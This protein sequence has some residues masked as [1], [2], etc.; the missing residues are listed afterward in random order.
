[1]SLD[2][3]IARNTIVQIVGRLIS[4]GAGLVVLAIMTRSLRTE[5]FGK[6]ATVIGFLQFIATVIDFGL[7]LTANRMLGA[8]S[9]K[10]E[11]AR[12]VGNIMAVRVITAIACLGIAPVIAFAGLPYPRD[13]NVGIAVV[14]FSFFAIALSQTL[15]P[16]FQ[17]YLAMHKAMIADLAGRV[18][19]I[20]GI[21]IAAAVNA[22]LFTFMVMI[23]AGSVT[24]FLVSNSLVRR[25]VPYHLAYDK[26]VWHEIFKTTWPIGLSI[27]FNLIYLRTDTLILSLYKS[28]DLSEVGFYSAAYR[29]LDILTGIATAFMGIMLPQLTAA[30]TTSNKELFGQLFQ[31][32]FNAFMMLAL[33]TAAVGLF[34]GKPL[35]AFIAGSEYARSGTI[36]SILI[37]AMSAVY[38]ST[39]YGH[40]IVVF[41]L[42]RRMIKGYAAA[43]VLGLSAYLITIPRY[44]V[45]GAAASTVGTEI[46][47]LIVTAYMASRY[48]H[49]T[50][51][52]RFTRRAILAALSMCLAFVTLH[53][54]P[55]V[56]PLL[57][58]SV[59]YGAGLIATKAIS[60]KFLMDLVR[61]HSKAPL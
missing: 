16:V 4:T 18:V 7:T 1:M 53:S 6:Y 44:G 22:S 40:V 34:L 9:S 30:W 27:M 39:L 37:I 59:L 35:L 24:T 25:I 11:D 45:W 55:V 2:R 28:H 49:L 23:V 19:L 58:G 15:V 56:I 36:L 8:S 57:V 52:W 48:G 61:I 43:A 31:K 5:G 51:N 14:T 38:F 13:V 20:G 33:P 41:G 32:S 17:K 21:I 54:F 60:K 50:I 46:F 12:I 26:K 29:V 3:S 10:E 47:I 42:Q